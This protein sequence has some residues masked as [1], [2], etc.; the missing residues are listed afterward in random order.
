MKK[1]RID[2]EYD[3]TDFHGWQYQPDRRTVQGELEKALQT[4]LNERIRITGAGRTDA[5][6]HALGQVAHFETNNNLDLERLRRAINA[7]TADDVHIKQI[8]QAADDFHSR[9]SA[10]AKLYQYNII[11]AP[12]PCRVRYNWYVKYRLD[13]ERMQEA[14]HHCLGEHDFK[15]F[16]AEDEKENSYCKIYRIGLTEE[17]QR[18]IIV[19]EGNRFLRKMVRGLVGFLTDIGRS[20]FPPHDIKKALDGVRY[21]NFFAPPQGLF[22]MEVRY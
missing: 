16:S 7:K 3:G 20:R 6:V 21:D 14:A 19:V 22:L 13:I 17:A 10:V 12:S 8:Q 2:I 1:I 4:I 15:G 18:I 5:G 11:S 9:F